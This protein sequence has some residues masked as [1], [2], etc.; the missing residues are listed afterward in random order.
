VGALCIDKAFDE[1]Y[2]LE[3]GKKLLMVVAAMVASH[4]INLETIRMEKEHLR[5]ENRRLREEIKNK[6]RV[7]NII[8]NINAFTNGI[9]RTK[10]FRISIC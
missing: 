4:V 3:E 9:C 5:E 6:Y 2:S 1:T 8:G 7:T 10:C